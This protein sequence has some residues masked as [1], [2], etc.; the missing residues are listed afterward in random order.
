MDLDLFREAGASTVYEASPS[1]L[2]MDPG[3]RA[4]APGQR[5]CGPAF[6]V[7]CHPG[8]NLA[9][10][11]ALAEVA[12]GDVVVVATDAADLGYWGEVTTTAALARGAAGLVIDGGV[13]DVDALRRRG[14]P[15][16]SRSVAIRGTVK[17]EPGR[18]RVALVC[19]GVPVRDRDLVVGDDDGVAVVPVDEVEATAERVRQ[20]MAKEADFMRRLAAGEVTL[21]LLNLRAVLRERGVEGG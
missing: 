10:H 12:E 3:I 17:S 8:D 4:L 19:G 13:R 9:I 11:R 2:A 18:L 15:T 1:R 20:R 5:V 16:W 6:T 14:F 7:L 21:D